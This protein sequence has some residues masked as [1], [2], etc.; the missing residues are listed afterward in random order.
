MESLAPGDFAL[1]Q[2][3]PFEVEVTVADDAPAN[4]T[5]TF[6]AGWSTETTSGGAFGYDGVFGVY[7]A[8][9]DDVDGSASGGDVNASASASSGGPASE[10]QGTITVTGL[11][12]GEHVIVEIWLVLQDE[13]LPG[14]TGNVQSRLIDAQTASGSVEPDDTINT[15]NQTVPLKRLRDFFEANVDVEVVKTDS[16]DPVVVGETFDYRLTVTNAGPSVANTVSLVQNTLMPSPGAM[17]SCSDRQS[18]ERP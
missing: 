15:G 6:V 2:I 3:V 16:K 13:I 1:G 11:D 14:T 7:G 8:F 4:D 5:I 10:I 12:P 18:S 9:V 17:I